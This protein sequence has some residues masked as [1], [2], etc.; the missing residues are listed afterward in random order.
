[1]AYQLKT[2]KILIIDDVIPMQTLLRS[3]LNTFGFQSIETANN[4]QDGFEKF[5]RYNPDLVLTDWM[6]E[7]LNGIELVERIRKDPLSPNRFVPI[8]LMTGFS[9]RLRVEYAR[10]VGVTEFLVKPFTAREL[11]ARIEHVIEK[12]R[13]F[14]GANGFFGPD[15]RRRKTNDYDGPSKRATDAPKESFPKKNADGQ[16]KK[17]AKLLKS[18]TKNIKEGQTKQ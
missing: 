1:M 18:I 10:D 7:P 3:I 14:V 6:M 15:R 17:D 11:Y 5:C 9:S 2:V 8:I 4:G 12:P 13:Q 16:S